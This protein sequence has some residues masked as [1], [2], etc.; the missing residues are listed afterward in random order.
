MIECAISLVVYAIV[1]LAVLFAV[2]AV[3]EAF[4][5]AIPAQIQKLFGVLALLLIILLALRCFVGV[6]P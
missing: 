4:G 5:V 2:R 3:V 1:I 6:A